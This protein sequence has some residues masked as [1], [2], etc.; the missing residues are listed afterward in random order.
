[1]SEV[2]NVTVNQGIVCSVAGL[3]DVT[4]YGAD[5]TGTTDSTTEINS[6]I[7]GAGI[8]GETV[9]FPAGD[10]LH[11][12]LEWKTGASATF[13]DCT[14][15]YDGNTGNGVTFDDNAAGISWHGKVT[16][17]TND[18]STANEHYG[19]K[20]FGLDDFYAENIHFEDMARGFQ[21]VLMTNSVIKTIT[22]KDISGTIQSG[23]DR[24]GSVLLMHACSDNVIGDVVGE[25]IWKPTLYLSNGSSGGTKTNNARITVNSVTATVDP[26]ST[27]GSG[28]G[29]RAAEDVT[30]GTINVTGGYRGVV[31]AIESADD[32]SISN[33][34]IESVV[35]RDVLNTTASVGV[36]SG[37]DNAATRISGLTIGAVTVNGVAN[38]G[39]QIQQTD[40]F[41]IG[42][43]NI[44]DQSGI[45]DGSMNGVRINR[46][47]A[48]TV[49]SISVD[50]AGTDGVRLLNSDDVMI[51]SII[52]TDCSR[53]TDG[54]YNSVRVDST[55]T[56]CF[57]TCINGISRATSNQH[58]R[59]VLIEA[60]QTS[61]DVLKSLSTNCVNS[62]TV[63]LNSTGYVEFPLP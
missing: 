7:I 35:C 49:A 15:I 36:Y 23:S 55:C 34:N 62:N 53:R 22:G 63:L 11:S 40:G 45:V 28:V 26:T 6:A 51:G 10:Y 13:N 17:K 8:A 54:L 46:C 2:I 1:M 44:N 43:V 24:I 21:A 3:H 32:T 18:P 39:L 30:I 14:L 60:T 19:M 58:A 12:G 25:N 5:R 52:V 29:I 56:Q 42:N 9:V 41:K 47:T 37:S 20:C 59:V 16:L 31:I 61:C 27:T 50:G 48:G 38:V 33:V 4:S 57:V